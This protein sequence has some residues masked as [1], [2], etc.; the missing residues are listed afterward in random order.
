MTADAAIVP[1]RAGTRDKIL[2]VAIDV[3]LEKGAHALSLRDIARRAGLTPMAIYR[4]Y[5]DK[6]ALVEALLE[7]GFQEYAD[8]LAIEQR[9]D[10]VEH[11]VALACRV[12]DFAVEKSAFFELMFF[13]SRTTMGMPG[14]DL[15]HKAHE[16]T[17]D[18][19]YEAISAC[20]Q[21]GQMVTCDLRHLT[22]DILAWCVGFSAFY[23]SAKISQ[24]P[25]RARDQFQRGF[26]R[27]I[28]PYLSPNS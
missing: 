19:A 28:F 24:D 2:S 21:S 23:M 8:Y 6:K 5:E 12:F 3:F 27:L 7:A 1:A 14:F 16:P 10:A 15:V 9:P 18:I 20:Q 17:Y 25:V 4:H 22:N 11:L 13:V 26:R